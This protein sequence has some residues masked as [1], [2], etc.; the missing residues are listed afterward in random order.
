M[1]HKNRKSTRLQDYDYA[2]PGAY[3]VTIV[4]KDRKCLFGNLIDGEMHLNEFGRFPRII[5]EKIPDHFSNITKDEFVT[6]PNHLHGILI[7]HDTDA[8]TIRVR[9][10]R[11]DKQS[12]SIPASPLRARG[13]VPGSLSAVIGYFKSGVSRRINALRHTP[14]ATVWQRSFYDRIIRN[15][16][17]YNYARQYILDNP[18]KWELDT[19][20]PHT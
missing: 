8:P 18:L 10:E 19:M 16:E 1:S 20:N 5:L 14:G 13:V 12:V 15:E 11:V 2:S 17:E 6:M 9:Q 3:F 4:T 7:I